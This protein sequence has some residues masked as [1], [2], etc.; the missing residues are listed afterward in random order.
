MAIKSI[1]EKALCYVVRD[2][3]LLVLRHTDYS[4]EQVGIQVPGGSVRPGESPGDAAVREAREETGL[5][6]FVIVRKLG[7]ATYDISPHRFEIQH[8]HFF[9]VRLAEPALERWASS[10]L[11]DGRRPPTNLECFWIPLEAAHV[12]QSGQGALLGA[13]YD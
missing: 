3:R 6:E 10:E 1:T 5:T 12:L 9:H 8:R 13:L 4:D 11:H 2:G 7:E